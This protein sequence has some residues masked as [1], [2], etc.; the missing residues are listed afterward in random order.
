VGLSSSG[1][2]VDAIELLADGH[3]LVSTTDS[4]SVS[5]VS[6]K[7][8]DLLEFTPT[9]WERHRRNLEALLRRE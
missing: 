7:D 4:A 2:D 5:G 8:E 3:L 9:S 1:E 6:A